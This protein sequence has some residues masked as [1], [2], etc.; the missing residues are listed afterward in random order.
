MFLSFRARHKLNKRDKSEE[1]KLT[2]IEEEATPRKS[3]KRN[4]RVS[5]PI[6]ENV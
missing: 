3:K 4:S 5:S 6:L 1:F 2:E